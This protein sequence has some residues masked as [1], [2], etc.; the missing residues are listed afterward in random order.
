MA[1]IDR[2]QELLQIFYTRR[3]P[4]N[5]NDL[6][7]LVEYSPATLKRYIKKLREMG[8]PVR[9]DFNA[10]GY[11]LDKTDDDA[12]QFPGLWFNVSELHSLLAINELIDQLDPGLLKLELMPLRKLIEKRLN[13]RG[14][15]TGELGRRIQLTG[16]GIRLCCPLA[17]RAS[18]SALLERKHL[19]LRYHSRGRDE[20][21]IRKVSPQRLIY[22]R[23]NWYLA[24]YCHTRRALRTLALERMSEV[25]LQESS[26]LE[27]DELELREHFN[28]SFGIFSGRPVQEAAL[29]FSRESARW[30]AEEQWHPDQRAQWLPDGGYELRIPYSDERELVMEI[31]RYGPDVQVAG[32]W[33]LRRA[34]RERLELALQHYKKNKEK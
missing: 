20:V 12:F 10:Q 34:V 14:I 18:A 4:I 21:G 8:A 31:L 11:V 2:L 32:P 13:Y 3:Y 6:L 33:Q 24:V 15:K 29:V 1:Q 7:N 22:Y 5:L 25:V 17:F 16:V 30:V 26:C 19:K 27:V 9:Y 23:S 28:T